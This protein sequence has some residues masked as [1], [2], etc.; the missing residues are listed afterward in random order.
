MAVLASEVLL[1]ELLQVGLLCYTVPS[2]HLPLVIP[3]AQVRRSLRDSITA[4]SCE[5]EVTCDEIVRA[6]HETLLNCFNSFKLLRN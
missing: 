5:V 2:I 1:F 3:D 4:T 6:V